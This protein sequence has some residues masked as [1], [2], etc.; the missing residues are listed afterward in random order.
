MIE[1]VTVPIIVKA[2]E[3]LFDESK[4][5]LEER[6]IR[7]QGEIKSSKSN[8]SNQDSLLKSNDRVQD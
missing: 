1:A 5:I 7:R 6:R 8:N 4:K 2:V 3:F